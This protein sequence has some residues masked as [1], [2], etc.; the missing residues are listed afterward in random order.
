MT[1]KVLYKLGTWCLHSVRTPAMWL[2]G[3]RS[4]RRHGAPLGCCN[5]TVFFKVAPA[6]RKWLGYW[7]KC[8]LLFVPMQ[9]LLTS[10][11]NTV[12]KFSLLEQIYFIW[13]MS[14]ISSGIMRLSIAF[15]CHP[16]FYITCLV[17]PRIPPCWK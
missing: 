17:A 2:H 1:K 16:L 15:V 7:Q 4:L 9:S 5:T 3:S 14:W 10:F 12:K 11:C 8:C 13:I 6:L